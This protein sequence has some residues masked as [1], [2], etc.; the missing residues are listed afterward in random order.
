MVQIITSSKTAGYQQ[1]VVDSDPSPGLTAPI[2]TIA[3]L[4]DGSARWSKDGTGDTDWNPV[5]IGDQAVSLELVSDLAISGSTLTP[6]VWNSIDF[7][8]TTTFGITIGTSD[9]AVLRD[10]FLDAS[11]Q[12]SV[13]F[14]SGGSDNS[15]TK[16]R[17]F[18]YQDA[19][20]GGAG[21]FTRV[22]GTRGWGYHRRIQEGDDTLV[23][24]RTFYVTSGTVLRYAVQRLAGNGALSLDG[25]GC[26][27][28]L[29]RIFG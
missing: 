2:G 24:N 28:R 25:E 16:A 5:S 1:F 6:V 10:S 13:I 14:S 26:N 19:T 12:F 27:L 8:D 18:L 9:I 17:G 11:G 22:R 3:M 29:R 20:N 23:L 15:R 4:E 7:I 21:P